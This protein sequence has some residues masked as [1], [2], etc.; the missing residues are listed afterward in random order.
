MMDPGNRGAR[1]LLEVTTWNTQGTKSKSLE[2]E[3]AIGLI[4]P[5]VLLLQET[6]EKGELWVRGYKTLYE[7]AED[8]AG[9]QGVGIA[10]HRDLEASKIGSPSPHFC[11][12]EAK[13]LLGKLTVGSVYMPCG[14]QTTTMESL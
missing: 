8:G 2:L 1:R 11:L 7:P 13:G 14:E 4:R 5:D 3:E 10:I 9:K 6:L 12:C